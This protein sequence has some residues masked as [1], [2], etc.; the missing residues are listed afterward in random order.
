MTGN[1]KDL[2]LVSVEF[3][4]TD[5][6]CNGLKWQENRVGKPPVVTGPQRR[7]GDQSR[8]HGVGGRKQRWAPTLIL[9][10]EI[11]SASHLP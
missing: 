1:R 3:M 2:T 8:T 4:K 9:M 7:R 10:Q 6:T 5:P 11:R